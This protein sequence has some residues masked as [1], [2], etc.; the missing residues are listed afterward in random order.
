MAEIMDKVIV[1]GLV[2]L[3]AVSVWAVLTPHHLFIG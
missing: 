2:I 1:L 3:A